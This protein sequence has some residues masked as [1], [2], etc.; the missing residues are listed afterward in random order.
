M[1][2]LI[3]EYTDENQKTYFI[4][5]NSDVLR[6]YE[7]IWINNPLADKIIIYTA[8]F[9]RLCSAT[10]Q[11]MTKPI[12]VA[13]RPRMANPVFDFLVYQ[14]SRHTICYFLMRSGAVVS[15]HGS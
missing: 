1:K 6:N 13:E 10:V 15:S 12:N 8:W 3:I 14:K 9:V 4:K 7:V 2:T 11:K 5:E